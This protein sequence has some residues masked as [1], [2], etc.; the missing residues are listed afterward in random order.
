LD[1]GV[2]RAIDWYKRFGIHQTFTHLRLDEKK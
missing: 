1:A 2:A